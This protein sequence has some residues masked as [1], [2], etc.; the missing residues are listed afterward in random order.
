MKRWIKNLQTSQKYEKG[1]VSV[2]MSNYNTPVHYLKLSIDS[3]L[4]QIYPNFEFIIIDDGS[5]DNSLE[6][7]KS[8]DDPRIRLICNESNLGLTKSLNLGI[9]LSKGE[10]IARMDSDDICYPERFEEQVA[11]LRANED[12]IVCGSWVDVIDENGHKKQK[13]GYCDVIPDMESYRICLLFGNNPTI[14]HP[15]T[16]INHRLL[17]DYHIAYHEEYR[18]A[19][20]YRLWISCAKH[21]SCTIIPKH[22]IQ[23]RRH[24]KAISAAK[25]K[26]QTDCAYRI[27]QEQLDALHLR[28][29]D[30]VIPFHHRLLYRNWDGHDLKIKEWLK[31][32]I[33]ANRKYRVYNQKKLKKILWNKWAMICYKEIEHSAFLTRCYI[34]KTMPVSSI[35]TM[36]KLHRNKK[37]GVDTYNPYDGSI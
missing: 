8:Y 2:V 34:I 25:R 14:M 35:L 12:V 29:T 30:N 17:S 19:Q 16:M 33:R 3:V 27:I 36:L 23:Y 32:I 6:L 20:D 37:R 28:L 22:L 18:Y 4:T 9:K 13:H 21:A 15:S 5:T 24:N 31:T 10:F 1:L 11:Y 7:I 26:G